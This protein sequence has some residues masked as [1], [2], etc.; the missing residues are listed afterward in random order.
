MTVDAAIDADPSWVE[1]WFEPWLQMQPAWWTELG[2]QSGGEPGP[3]DLPARY[4]EAGPS[5][6]LAYRWF[7]KQFDIHADA[8][9]P[10]E[11]L[12]ALPPH[13][14]LDGQALER[15]A[16]SLGR[17]A[18]VSHCMA[19]SRRALAHLFSAEHGDTVFWRDALR[20]AKARPMS[21]AGAPPPSDGSAIALQ[22]WAIPL[23]ARLIDDALPGAWARLRLRCDPAI[24]R[25]STLQS[26]PSPGLRRQAWRVWRSDAAAP[27]SLL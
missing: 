17:I 6:R 12:A 4:R 21:A 19:N 13:L 20:Q 16:L 3:S 15:V 18:Y 23:M 8:A 26:S 10:F 11:H 1:L 25:A 7:C 9:F 27:H 5:L 2:N 24:V 22:R 14:P